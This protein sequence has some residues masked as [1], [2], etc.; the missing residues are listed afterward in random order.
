MSKY[1][2]VTGGKYLVFKIK[3]VF[4]SIFFTVFITIIFTT[5][6]SYSADC[7]SVYTSNAAVDCELFNGEFNG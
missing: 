2:N 3:K 6:N 5:S 4:L 7:D 1:L